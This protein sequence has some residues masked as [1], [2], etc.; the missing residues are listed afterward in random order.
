MLSALADGMAGAAEQAITLPVESAVLKE[1]ALPGYSIAQQKCSICHSADYINLQPP[2]MTLAQWNGEMVKMQHSYGA[3][4]DDTEIKLLSVY[5]TS[6]YG[7]ATTI[8]PAD[9]A[10]T[11]PPANPGASQKAP[12][13]AATGNSPSPSVDVNAILAHNACLSCHALQT[14]VVG[15]AYHDVAAKYKDDPQAASKVADHIRAGGSGK[16]GAIPMPSFPG[17]S[18]QELQALAAFV[19]QK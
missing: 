13:A 14:K 2:R 8:T 7:D 15:P 4:I 1:S 12:V 3:P 10:S 16:W 17:L 11:L 19:L 5:L 18:P 9:A 6:A